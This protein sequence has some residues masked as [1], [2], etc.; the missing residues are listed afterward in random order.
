MSFGNDILYSVGATLSS[1][2]WGY[3]LLRTGKWR[4]DW[5]S[6]FGHA[7][8]QARDGRKTLLIHA[9]SVGEVNAIRL[10]V[11]QL[12]AHG[13]QLK[14]I[15]SVTTDTGMARA[16]Q[17]FGE[18]HVVVRYPLDFT[19]SVR[20][21]LEAVKPDAVALVELE[22]WP[23]FVDECAKRGVPVMV[24]NGRLSARSYKRYGM[25]RPL[26]KPTFAKLAAAAAQDADYAERFV[27]MGV[28]AERVTVTGTMK[29]DTTKIVDTLPGA[30]ALAA[31]LGIDRRR[32]LIVCGSSGPGEEKLFIEALSGLGDPPAQILIAPRKPERFDEAAAAMGNPVRRRDC[33]DGTTRPIDARGVFLLDTIGELGRAYALA[34]VVV[35]GRSFCPLHG[36]DMTEPIALGRPVV[37]GPN[38]EDFADMMAKLVAGGGIVQVAEGTS[39]RA[40]VERL[41][42]PATGL[43]LAQ[44]GRD[45]LKS[46]QGATRRNVQMILKQM[47]LISAES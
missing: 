2:L 16:K 44:R 47:K 7:P 46:Q 4:T 8:A 27:G 19:S 33:Q 17:L 32:K 10:L 21:F 24:I 35:I 42:D 1:P 39:L 18:R 45:V 25:V 13:D 20:R 5:A 11:T 34:D 28:A 9:V 31:T 15:I 40:A 23:T 43:A 37:I 38:V 12:E 26:L 22:V 41:L 30:D 29:W 14:V 3:R 36:S 6:R